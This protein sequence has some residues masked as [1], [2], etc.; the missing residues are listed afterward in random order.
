[1]NKHLMIAAALTVVCAVCCPAQTAEAPA[2]ATAKV[3][4]ADGSQLLGMPRTVSLALVTVFGKQEIPLAQVAVLDF[5]KDIAKVKFHNKDILSGKLE[6]EGFAL[7]TVFKEVSLPYAQ[8]KSVQFFRQRGT[9]LN[10]VEPGLL[11]HVRFDAEDEDL[12]RFDARMEARNVQIVE[13]PEGDAMLVGTT[14]ARV[15]I[16]LPFVPYKMP[17]GTIEF[18]AKLPQARQRFSHVAS[19]QPLFFSIECPR[20]RYDHHFVF[21]FVS[22]NG[23]ARAGLHGRIYGIGDVATHPMGAVSGIA[24]TGLL[25]NTPDEWHH[26]TFI[27]KREGF[28]FPN[29]QGKLLALAVNGNIVAAGGDTTPQQFATDECIL[30]IHDKRN[31]DCSLPI[32][33]SDLKVWD[34]ARLPDKQEE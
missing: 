1:M 15:T 8:I 12:S 34:Y 26:Y 9:T 25:G 16:H 19:G 23:F 18:W 21:G 14:D 2:A 20:L 27:W 10:A 4:L 13:G 17:E 29:V 31:S 5:D 33:M 6:G 7:T 11:L 28:D 32:V 22:N 30:I 24:D 3:T